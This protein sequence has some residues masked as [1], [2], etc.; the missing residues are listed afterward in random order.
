MNLFKKM[1]L[2]TL[3][4]ISFAAVIIIGFLVASFGRFQL[5]Q[6]SGNIETLAQNRLVKLVLIHNY[7]DNIN[8]VAN[9][10]RNMVMMTDQAQMAAE[11]K[12]I[13][14]TIDKST[15]IINTFSNMTVSPDAKILLKHLEN[16]RPE[17]I[18]ALKKAEALALENQ[19]EEAKAVILNEFQ[20]A[21]NKVF[22]AI[23]D[24]INYQKNATADLAHSSE[25]RADSAGQ[26]MLVLALIAM[27]IGCLVAW[28]ITR[29]VRSKLGG[30]PAD[31]ASIAQQIAQGN[32]ITTIPIRDKDSSSV[33]AA[34]DQMRGGLINIVE[35]VSQSSHAIA[36]G[37]NEIAAGTN[38]LSQRTEEQAASLQQTAASMEQISNAVSH[39]VE[40]IRMAAELANATSQTA[41]KGNQV[42]GD[43]VATMADITQ[44]SHQIVEII[45]L[46]D[47]IAFQTNI[48]A[49]NAGV[50]AARAGEEGKGFA[51][52]AHEVRSL[53]Q[54]S[55]SAAREIKSLIIE[56]VKKI[57]TGADRV[58]L[59]GSTISELLE[60]SRQVAQLINEIGITTNEQQQG[61]AQIN[62]AIAQLD[63]VTHQN[64]ALVEESACATDNLNHQAAHLV[65]VISVFVVDD[66]I[67]RKRLDTADE[68]SLVPVAGQ[69]LATH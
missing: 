33:L 64:A 5:H 22:N 12:R 4:S 62:T 6:L 29:Q 60:Q 25:Q 51:V 58:N 54:H 65:E 13:R 18:Q 61:I 20:P 45:S 24:I 68:H 36:S 44:S 55:A 14:E 52:V 31:A 2:G 48:L 66:V 56:S 3:L 16:V 46:I 37:A 59:A 53:A 41:S 67:S 69:Q 10:I 40:T 21:Q 34:I 9:A 43:V 30:E 57:E 11:S 7:K 42:V 15:E 8:I 63:Q 27:A 28:F 26:T 1:K 50:E 19:D 17:N 38:D 32:L 35:Q 23:D 39:N 49:L 47:N